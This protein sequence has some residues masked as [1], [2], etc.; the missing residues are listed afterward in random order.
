MNDETARRLM[1]SQIGCGYWGPNLLRNLVASKRCRVKSVADI[2]A[3]R[4]EF[5]K[6]MY[7][8]IQVLDN[9]EGVFGDPEVAAVIL[10]TPV[11]THNACRAATAFSWK[12]LGAHTGRAFVIYI[13]IIGR[14]M[15]AILSAAFRG[16][17]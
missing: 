14:L 17:S 5:V 7:S 2:S 9:A 16:R 8:P 6:D 4:R 15:L 13:G 10:A 3:A 1:V 12:K 11:A